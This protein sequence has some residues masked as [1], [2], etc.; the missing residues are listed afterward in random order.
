MICLSAALLLIILA[1]GLKPRGFRLDNK[2]SWIKGQPG[3]RFNRFGIAYTNP[4]DSLIANRKSNPDEFSFEIAMRPVSY[5]G[6]RFE[7]ILA[8][9][10]GDD[11]DQLIM[12]QWRS[13]LIVMNGDDY[14][15]K[16]KTNR[17]SVDASASAPTTWFVTIASGQDGT[18]IFI[19][20][21]LAAAKKD[22]KLEI[23]TGGKTRLVVG[24]SAN[25]KHPWRGDIYGLALYRHR[26]TSREI[27]LHF[28]RWSKDQTFAFA[29]DAG[30]FAL[31]LFDEMGGPRALDH[32]GAN[33]NLEIPSRMQVLE[34]KILAGPGNSF[35]L[36]RGYIIDVVLN[37][38]GFIPFAFILCA[39]LIRVGGAFDKHAVLMTIAFCFS[40]SLALE[41]LQAWMPSRSSSMLDLVLNTLGGC[42]G[43]FF[44]RFFY[45]AAYRKERAM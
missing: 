16:G 18:E 41:I 12:G 40:V 27:A 42:I 44:Y 19:D 24:N 23:P 37:L 1:A 2:V 39:T 6:Y 38:I 36:S 11:S 33:R 8:L 30:P 7:F 15:Y 45:R 35:N 9:H 26:L 22:L 4:L 43:A 10:N 34:K 29:T 13:W 20:G 3:I 17:I 31:Y 21:K 32:S 5:H 14:A 28:S 25:G